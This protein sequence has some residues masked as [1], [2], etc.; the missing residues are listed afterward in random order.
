MNVQKCPECGGQ[1]SPVPFRTGW[2]S[3]PASTV[4]RCVKC[5]KVF[6]F[7]PETKEPTAPSPDGKIPLAD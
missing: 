4:F 2:T 6:S 3:A 7:T 1:A 5:A